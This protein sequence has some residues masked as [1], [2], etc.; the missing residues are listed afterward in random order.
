M[1]R[2]VLRFN[3][4]YWAFVLA[5]VLAALAVPVALAQS[6]IRL[7]KPAATSSTASPAAEHAQALLAA[8]PAGL[9]AAQIDALV[10]TMD[11]ATAR[12]ALKSFLAERAA[13]ADAAAPGG[14]AEAEPPL[15]FYSR[16]LAEI[17]ATYA[18]MG[19]AVTNA[20]ARP[21]G[22]DRV[23]PVWRFFI[24]VVAIAAL[25][26]A[27]GIAIALRLH[28]R[29]DSMSG[30]LQR[31][32]GHVGADLGGVLAYAAVLTATYLL[33]RPANPA[34]GIALHVLLFE[35]ALFALVATA[36]RLVFQPS[37]PE[38]RIAALDTPAAK[39]VHGVVITTLALLVLAGIVGNFIVG[40][41]LGTDRA[42]ALALPIGSLAYLYV[43]AQVLVH[44]RALALYFADRFG[45]GGSRPVIAAI[46]PI[47]FAAYIVGLWLAVVDGALRYQ[48]GVGLRAIASLVVILAVP[49][50]ANL[51]RRALLRAFGASADAEAPVARLM[52]A[53]WIVV[54]AAA[55][56]ATAYLWGFNPDDVGIGD[57]LIRLVLNV[58]LIVLLG[59]VGW[60]LI[61][62]WID[63]RIAAAAADPDPTRSQRLKTLLPLFRNF[64]RV[65]LFV[66][67]AMLI[68]ASL[69]IQIGPL[70]AGAGV[71]GLAIGLGAQ[72]TIA[73]ILAGVFFLF[74]DAFRVGDYVEVGTL[75]GTVEGISI[76]SL[77]LRHQR[78]AVHTV[79]FGQIKS[80]TNQTRDWAL[81]RLEFRVPPDTDVALLK[82]LV[83]K[84]S[85]ELSAD[86]ELGKGFLDPLKSQ[87]V[88]RVEDNAI[89][90]AVKYIAKPGTQFAIRRE[91]FTRLLKAFQEN[92]IELVGRG[93]VV[94]VEGGDVPPAVAGAAA[95][96][97]LEQQPAA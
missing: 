97:A 6:P 93:V 49:L 86:P 5:V 52:G 43:A 94:K 35:G 23:F 57:F 42:A 95:S 89:V 62:R 45:L 1:P 33:V 63:L 64:L 54:A 11:D 38:L 12:A 9:T 7:P 47:A 4:V 32:L 18:D 61:Q 28:R 17:A 75:K 84:I 58:G 60:A 31:R 88:R 36:S 34:A 90:V 14:V 40:V 30:V 20:I 80:L 51:A 59:Y 3:L 81:V 26:A 19:T 50:V 56:V 44:R 55:V 83:K 46:L 92:G 77:K 22:T 53:V 24:N 96:A 70:L 78:G 79:P 41:G 73:D 87:G 15:S 74:E 2:F 71:V 13:T 48:P 82:K 72:Q 85:A 68:L 66:M 39:R 21:P 8:F 29:V 16:R 67:I 27:I 65:T 37:E 10:A 69:G 25:A 91:A 76:R